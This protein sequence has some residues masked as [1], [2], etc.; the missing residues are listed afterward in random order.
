MASADPDREKTPPPPTAVVWIS[1]RHAVVAVGDIEPGG[2]AAW[3][4]ERRLESEADFL[5]RIVRA[6]GDSGRVMVLGPTGPR[7][8]VQRAYVA[9]SQRPDRLVEPT[10]PGAMDP[11]ELAE[12]V[13]ALGA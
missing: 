3:S 5:A 6:V 9:I 10:R 13:R 7:L 8:A 4:T 1:G 2:I 11:L 12:R